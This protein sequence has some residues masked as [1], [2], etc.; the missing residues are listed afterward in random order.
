M[1]Y[2]PN[3]G[4]HQGEQP[5]SLELVAGTLPQWEQLPPRYQRE[6]VMVLTSLLVRQLPAMTNRSKEPPDEQA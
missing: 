6:L 5:E 3:Q 4:A 1:K 2:P